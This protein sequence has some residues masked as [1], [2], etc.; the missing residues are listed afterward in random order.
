FAGFFLERTNRELGKHI[1]GYEDEVMQMFL[2]YGWPGN[3]REFRN[4]V[5]RAVLLTTTDMIDRSVLP[6][7]ITNPQSGIQPEPA[8]SPI[9]DPAGLTREPDL[10]DIAAKAEFETIMNVLREVNFNKTRAAEI[11][12]IDR[13]TLY[14]KIKIYQSH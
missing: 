5:R 3:L 2:N 9:P 11:L 6:W 13:K 7:E 14:N 1:K 4:V 12:K 10:K 8:T